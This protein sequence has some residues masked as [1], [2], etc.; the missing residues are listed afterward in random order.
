MSTAVV[1][2]GRNLLGSLHVNIFIKLN[3]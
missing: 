2:I 1:Y 3:N